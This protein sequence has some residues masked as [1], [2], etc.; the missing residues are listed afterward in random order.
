LAQKIKNYKIFKNL[1]HIV[2]FLIVLYVDE[3]KWL[4]NSDWT[5]LGQRLLNIASW[6]NVYR[7]HSCWSVSC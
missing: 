2:L 3:L 7:L 5:A 4:I 1:L 6:I